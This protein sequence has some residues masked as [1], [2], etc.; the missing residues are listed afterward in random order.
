MVSAC[1]PHGFMEEEEMCSSDATFTDKNLRAN[2]MALEG[3]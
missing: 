2:L 1:S 3:E